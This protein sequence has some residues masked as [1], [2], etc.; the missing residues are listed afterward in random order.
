MLQKNL[1]NLIKCVI[2]SNLEIQFFSQVQ[3][4]QIGQEIQII[5]LSMIN[6]NLK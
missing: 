4:I 3:I 6:L 1:R 2:Y 5:F